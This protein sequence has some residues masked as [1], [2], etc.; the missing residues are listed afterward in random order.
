MIPKGTR[1]NGPEGQWLEFVE[2]YD[3]DKG[4]VE[5]YMIKAGDG[6]KDPVTGEIVPEWFNRWLVDEAK[7]KGFRT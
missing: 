1:A 3:F 7:K 2:D 6:A 4:Y 5:A